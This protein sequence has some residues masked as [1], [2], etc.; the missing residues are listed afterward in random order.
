V[1]DEGFVGWQA[2]DR[3]VGRDGVQQILQI[4]DTSPIN[5]SSYSVH[6]NLKS[7]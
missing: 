2:G 3:P 7:T 1:Q 4:R 5:I 6:Y